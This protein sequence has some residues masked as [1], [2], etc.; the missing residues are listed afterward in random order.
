MNIKNNED[1]YKKL[2]DFAKSLIEMYI[3]ARQ[4][5]NAVRDDEIIILPSQNNN[6]SVLNWGGTKVK[7]SGNE[8]IIRIYPFIVNKAFSCE[9]YLKL[10]LKNYNFDI[11][12][13]KNYERHNLFKL[14]ENTTTEFKEEMF[15]Y[16]FKIYGKD[17]N[18]EF[19]EK[20]IYNISDV[21]KHWRYIYEHVNEVNE[22]NNGFLNIF[23]NYLD[24]YCIKTIYKKYNY[25]VKQNMR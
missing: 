16:F 1:V 18:K 21:F 22:V 19:I 12:S 20:Q 9:V 13:L 17:A 10:L 2:D 3:T 24:N 4:F 14:Y 5:K 8:T 7:F 11:N 23:C 6:N 15:D 25:D